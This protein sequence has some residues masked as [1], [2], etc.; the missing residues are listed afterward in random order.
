[1]DVVG[2]SGARGEPEL[3]R[4]RVRGRK[5]TASVTHVTA[6]IPNQAIADNGAATPDDEE[7]LGEARGYRRTTMNAG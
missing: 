5:T 1:M 7:R 6:M 3:E 2:P 4:G